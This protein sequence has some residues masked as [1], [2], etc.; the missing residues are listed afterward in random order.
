[1]MG[2][3]FQELDDESFFLNRKFITR[4]SKIRTW[5]NDYVSGS[6]LYLLFFRKLIFV[7]Y[8]IVMRLILMIK[9]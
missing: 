4:K 7:L 1:M 3:I 5:D 6:Y 2:R 9:F 8:R